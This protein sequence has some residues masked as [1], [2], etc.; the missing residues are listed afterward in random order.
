MA[1]EELDKS[2]NDWINALSLS[3][4]K[5]TDLVQAKQV[6]DAA[7]EFKTGVAAT[8][9][10]LYTEVASAYPKRFENKIEAE[11]WA[12]WARLM[13]VKTRKIE[14]ALNKGDAA[15]A[16]RLLPG[17]REHFY[18]LHVETKSRKANDYIYALNKLVQGSE[19]D[20]ADMES[21]KSALEK[22]P[23]SIK[24]KAQAEDYTKART[25]WA[26][27]VDPILSDSEVK[28]EELKPLRDAT[29]K[30]YKAYGI[31]FE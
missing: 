1:S 7:R 13:Y 4:V 11:D 8:V 3:Y 5:T 19:I 17:L 30:F 14:D 16:A 24:A 18:A 12:D 20:A 25:E 27:K 31:Q 22:A 21:L 26:S 9:R 10:K 23:P 29:R 28:P 2:W 6:P 15:A